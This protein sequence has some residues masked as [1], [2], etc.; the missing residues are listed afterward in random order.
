MT[1]DTTLQAMP[2]WSAECADVAGVPTVLV[3]LPSGNEAITPEQADT[4][5]A[6]LVKA[7]R[8]VRGEGER[9]CYTCAHRTADNDC[10]LLFGAHLD[11]EERSLAIT[12]YCQDSG[13]Y[14]ADD[15]MPTDLSVRCPAHKAKETPHV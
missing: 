9:S 3:H 14:D 8:E 5:A 6:Q 13:A 15:M 12:S 11:D 2:V 1:P 4:L 7:A 10:A